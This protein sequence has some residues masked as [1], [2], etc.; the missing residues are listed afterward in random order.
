MYILKNTK[1]FF[2]DLT[3]NNYPV[4]ICIYCGKRTENP[5]TLLKHEKSCFG[6]EFTPE[7]VLPSKKNEANIMTFKNLNKAI[8]LPFVIFADFEAFTRPVFSSTPN[9]NFSYTEAQQQHTPCSYGLKL[10]CNYDDKFTKPVEIYRGPDC[11]LKF[12]CRLIDINLECNEIFDR[13]ELKLTP[14]EQKSFD[15]AKRCIYCKKCFNKQCKLWTDEIGTSS[16]PVSNR[17]YH[18]FCYRDLK[19]TDYDEIGD[20]PIGIQDDI[21]IRCFICHKG[22]REKAR[23]HCHVTGKYRGAAHNDCN[24]NARLRRFIPVIMHNGRNYDWHFIIKGLTK[25]INEKYKELRISIIPLNYEKFITINMRI[26]KQD[27]S[28]AFL[29]SLNFLPSSLEKLANDLEPE[30]FIYTD[31]LSTNREFVSLLKTKRC[32]SL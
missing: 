2:A 15:E 4:Y 7:L 18:D 17:Y 9:P 8:P 19:S 3:K 20:L 25:V 22:F 6:Q 16:K 11:I 14:E 5:N 1:A 31:Q 26:A 21:K 32:I 12:L 10:I 27:V 29:D 13:K 24:L 28:I 23:D 30:D